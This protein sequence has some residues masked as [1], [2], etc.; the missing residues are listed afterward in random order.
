MNRQ[1]STTMSAHQR[2]EAVTD[3]TN[4]SQ[5]SDDVIV[6]CLRERFMSDNIYTNIGSS[7]LVA[8]NPHK[9]VSSNADSIL[10]KYAAEYRDTSE[11]KQALPPHIFQMANNAYYHMKRTTQDQAILFRYVTLFF[12]IRGLFDVFV[13]E[14]Q[15]AANQRTD[16]S[17]SKHCSSSASPTRAKKAPNSPPKSPPP[18]SCSRRSETHAPS[19]TP[20]PR[21]S[22]N[23]P[24]SSSQSG[25]D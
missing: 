3:L 21:G 9:Y 1:S 24:N 2:M 5:V 15:G 12:G 6:A 13:A 23:T 18:N 11:H 22:E 17:P 20:T 7:T 8:L 14:R 25:A 4:L 16:G 10:H 19:S